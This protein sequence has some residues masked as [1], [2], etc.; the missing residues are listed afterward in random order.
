M[1]CLIASLVL[2]AACSVEVEQSFDVASTQAEETVDPELAAGNPFE[3]R[4]DDQDRCVPGGTGK[5]CLILL[6]CKTV[7][8][9]PPDGVTV[10]ALV[11]PAP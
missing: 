6:D 11:T 1:R 7:V 3:T 4:C 9:A 2:L 5:K 8:S 10:E